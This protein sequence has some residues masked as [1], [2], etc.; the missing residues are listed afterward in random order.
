MVMFE[1]LLVDLVPYNKSFMDND[2]RWWNSETIFWLSMGDRGFSS[3]GEVER[4]HQEWF[5]SE[6]EHSGLTFGVLSKDGKPLG[7]FG[8]NWI[9]YHSRT[10]NFGAGIF[11]PD[12]LGGGYGTDALTLLIDYC[13]NWLDMRKV[14]LVTMSLN[15]RVMRQMEKVGFKLEVRQ[16]EGTYANG[17][18]A[19][20][21]MYGLMRD[22]W[23]GRET[24]IERLGLQAVP[25]KKE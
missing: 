20:V 9:D 14:W 13:F 17:Q 16:R 8:I 25:P 10:A 24:M 19:D 18:L 15:V 11:E 6:K 1:G 21:V 22:E 12:Y 23:P 5:S 3:K 4:E 7:F 2:H